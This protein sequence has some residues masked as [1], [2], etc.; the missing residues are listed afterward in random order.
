MNVIELIPDE[1]FESDHTDGVYDGKVID[2]LT[3]HERWTQLEFAD[4][5]MAIMGNHE[6]I[7]VEIKS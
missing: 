7:T 1:Y 2:G 3:I 6:T 5:S 4:G